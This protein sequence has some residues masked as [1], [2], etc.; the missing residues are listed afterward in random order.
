VKQL[1]E[2]YN[3][4]TKVVLLCLL[5]ASPWLIV[6]V[7]IFIIAPNNEINEMPLC[8]EK[9]GNCAHLGGGDDY[10]LNQN[11]ASFIEIPA[12]QIYQNLLDYIAD[13]NGK[14]MVKEA[15]DG[16]YFVH[17]VEV[18]SFWNFPDDVIVFIQASDHNS[19]IEIHSESRIGWGDIGLNPERIDLIYS[20]VSNID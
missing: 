13:N 15:T 7:G 18:T 6:Q 19:I 17:F 11:Y 3:L 10:R 9:S 5:I 14:V 8:P 1:L 4:T 2:R 20:A 16:S 12:T